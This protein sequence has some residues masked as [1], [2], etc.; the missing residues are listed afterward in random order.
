MRL[1]GSCWPTVGAELA[2]E[3]PF[4]PPEQVKLGVVGLIDP[5]A[6]RFG[7][8]L[9]IKRR[10][11]LGGHEDDRL[12]LDDF[13]R[14]RAEPGPDDRQV[15]QPRDS[16]R[17]GVGESTGAVRRSPS[18]CPSRSSTTVRALR[19]VIEGTMPR[20][21][22]RALREIEL[23]DD[24]LDVQADHVVGEDLREEGQDRA[25][26]LELNRDH[27]RS[28]GDRGTLRHR[29]REHSADQ[30]PSGLT[31]ECD[32]VRLGEDLRQAVGSQGVDEQRE[33]PRLENAEQLRI[34]A[35][36]G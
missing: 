26:A 31:V 35:G 34:G 8:L 4:D 5:V 6:G 7:H 23:A 3:F 10:D 29:E 16:D 18:V 2:P 12:G 17:G 11:Q 13:R 36:C 21:D 14:I 24:R 27:G 1:S 33:M 32:Q 28:A 9:L 19:S 20:T 22:R 30:E 25:E 15:A